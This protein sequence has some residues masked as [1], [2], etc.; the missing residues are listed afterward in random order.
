MESQASCGMFAKALTG[1]S[2]DD[3]RRSVRFVTITVT[4]VKTGGIKQLE[5]ESRESP[6][7]H[8]YDY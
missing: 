7:R 5:V 6:V 8:Y 2:P 4:E 1:T 3:G